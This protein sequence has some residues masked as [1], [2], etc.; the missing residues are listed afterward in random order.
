MRLVIANSVRR[1]SLAIYHLISNAR[2]WN[3]IYNRLVSCLLYGTLFLQ[4]PDRERTNQSAGICVR[5]GLPYNK[6]THIYHKDTNE[7]RKFFQ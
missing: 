6:H 5:L 7:I 4:N 3:Y 2:S 1:A